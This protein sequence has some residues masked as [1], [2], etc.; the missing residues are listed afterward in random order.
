MDRELAN[1]VGYQATTRQSTTLLA[2]STLLADPFS[3]ASLSGVHESPGIR[4]LHTD[5]LPLLFDAAIFNTV[6][7][8]SYWAEFLESRIRLYYH[9][10][11]RYR[12]YFDNDPQLARLFTPTIVKDESTMAGLDTHI[13]GTIQARNDSGEAVDIAARQLA[14]REIEVITFALFR[15]A[16][17]RS[18]SVSTAFQIRASISILYSRHHMKLIPGVNFT[19]I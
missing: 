9:D 16:T 10:R 1:T 6:S 12:F 5:I 2:L 8:Y 15:N 19:R 7:D 13:I 3:I 14:K 4:P 11:T 17:D 18:Y